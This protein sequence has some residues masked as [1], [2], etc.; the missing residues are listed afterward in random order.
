MAW[1]S[2]IVVGALLLAAEVVLPTD[3]FI[4][5]FGAAAIVVGLVQ[6]VG[7]G[8]PAWGQWL[9]FAGLSVTSL[10][11][12]RPRLRRALRREETVG[13]TEMVGEIV[14]VGDEIPP[15]GTGKGELRGTV[16]VVHNAGSQPLRAGERCQVASVEGL[17]LHVRREG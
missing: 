13:H 2:W 3:F 9:L 10:L 8:L 14:T 1:W 7:L 11:L 17:T 16:W 12:L 6:L 4:V 15:Q 5:F